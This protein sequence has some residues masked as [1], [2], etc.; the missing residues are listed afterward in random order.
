MN[1][2]GSDFD[3]TGSVMSSEALADMRKKQGKCASCGQRCFKKKVLKLIPLTIPDLVDNGKCLKCGPS[4]VGGVGGVE[5]TNPKLG[6]MMP[7]TTSDPTFNNRGTS[8]SSIGSGSAG[9]SG[10][11]NAPTKLPPNSGS[12]ARSITSNS[13]MTSTKDGL[14]P[15]KVAS[16]PTPTEPK[17]G[18][19]QEF[20][21]MEEEKEEDSKSFGYVKEEK[22][23]SSP[24]TVA[25]LVSATSETSSAPTELKEKKRTHQTNTPGA[26]AVRRSRE[27]KKKVSSTSTASNASNAP[28]NRPKAATLE[29]NNHKTNYKQKSNMVKVLKMNGLNE[30]AS[31]LQKEISVSTIQIG[32]TEE[33]TLV[34]AV[35]VD[36]MEREWEK[37]KGEVV[38]AVP[39]PENDTRRCAVWKYLVVALVVGLSAGLAVVFTKGALGKATQ[40]PTQSPTQTPTF[41]PE[42]QKVVDI[43][44]PFVGD[45]IYDYVDDEMSPQYKASK[46]LADEY[47]DDYTD[48]FL[49]E[50]YAWA[51]F[52]YATNG[53]SW[54]ENENYLSIEP[55]ICLKYEISCDE[56]E[57]AIVEIDL[58]TFW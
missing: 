54:R 41:P 51:V 32:G 9:G 25:G 5:S 50:R 14:L 42:I 33:G 34:S 55:N 31:S 23:N 37:S 24:S 17:S 44:E 27:A 28:K 47:D 15:K 7:T 3:S 39:I 36:D 35:T 46:W 57:G 16:L 8:A 49:V 22:T 19:S 38:A 13:S 1:N 20:E 53:E 18:S 29:L 30:S 11:F 21:E 6:S 26:V 58:S 40:S 52:F 45:D 10:R 56:D 2:L 12:S 43:L 4:N 48:D